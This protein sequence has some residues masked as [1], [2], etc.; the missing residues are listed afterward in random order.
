MM[1]RQPAR[2]AAA[3]S[4]A[5][6]CTTAVKELMDRLG[7]RLDPEQPA[8]GLSIADQQIVEIAKAL[9]L[10]RARADHGRADRRA[11]RPRG[12]AAVRRGAG[13]ARARRRGA[14]H[15]PPAR[16]DL[17]DLRQRSPC[18]ATATVTHDGRRRRPH[19]RTSWSAGWSA[20]SSTQLFPKQAAEIGAP[21]LSVR[22]LTR[23]GVF[24]DVSFEVRRG[25]IVGL[26]GLVGAGRSEVARA[27]FGVDTPRRAARSR[28]T[29]CRLKPGSP[30]AGDARRR[31]PR[32][33]GPPPAGPGDGAVDRAQHRPDAAAAR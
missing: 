24:T 27:V 23:E 19:R 33:R 15:L 32:A 7:V 14:V 3:A 18:C 4:T 11:V 25:E 1:G 12:R 9:S 2:V 20:A 31:R 13:A 26:A 5:A 16:G 8:R 10:R 17:R 30:R 6:R 22:R 28:S 21:V 29:A